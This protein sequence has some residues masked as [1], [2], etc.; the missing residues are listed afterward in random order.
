MTRALFSALF[1]LALLFPVCSARSQDKAPQQNG[2]TK[3]KTTPPA[4]QSS[5]TNPP[6]EA[7]PPEEDES[8]KPRTYAFDPLEA[9]RNINVGNFYMHQGTERGYRAAVGRYEDATKYNPNSAEAFFKL[10]EAEAKL[11]NK[12]AAT[13]AFRRVLQL[14]PDSKFARQAKKKLNTKS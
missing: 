3:P 6:E 11:K 10:G 8:V 1:A 7:N 9:Q 4:G 13:A 14:A 2:Q 12:D 5:V